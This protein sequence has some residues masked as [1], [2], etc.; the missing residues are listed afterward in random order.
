MEKPERN[1]VTIEYCTMCM[2]LPAALKLA[3]D[4]LK[5]YQ[6]DLD[7]VMLQP[8]GK[9]VFEVY[10]NDEKV[11]SKLDLDRYPTYEEIKGILTE[12]VGPPADIFN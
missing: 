4:I 2:D 3:D 5:D 10:H 1:Y 11:F 9:A 7:G 12:R 8:G 6:W